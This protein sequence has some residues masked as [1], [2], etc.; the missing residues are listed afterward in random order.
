[1][2]LWVGLVVASVNFLPEPLGSML[3][4][5]GA[6]PSNGKLPGHASMSAMNVLAVLV[7]RNRS[8]VPNMFLCYFW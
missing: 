4:S 2:C 1:M 5:V 8:T 6:Y 7:K 3:G